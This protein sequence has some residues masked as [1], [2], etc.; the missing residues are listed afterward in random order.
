[1]GPQPD[2]ADA[3]A[4]PGPHQRGLVPHTQTGYP[5]TSGRRI[6]LVVDPR[7]PDATGTPLN[8]RAERGYTVG[9]AIRQ[10]V[11]PGSWRIDPPERGT[12]RPV[13]VHFDRP[14]DHALV[15]RCLTILDAS[16]KRVP[17][18]GTVAAGERHWVFAPATPWADTAY[19]LLAARQLEDVAGNSITRVFDRDLT[20]PRDDPIPADTVLLTLFGVPLQSGLAGLTFAG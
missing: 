2:P 1:V 9:P 15:R 4:R 10:R 5:L 18:E 14:M 13:R 6:S 3:P 16:G 7:F 11:S 8:T 17:G 12:R 19:T 20:D